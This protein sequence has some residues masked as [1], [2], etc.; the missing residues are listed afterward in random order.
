MRGAKIH[1]L[2]YKEKKKKHLLENEKSSAE[3]GGSMRS[4]NE[5]D[6]YISK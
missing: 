3:L 6:H 4:E 2:G 5:S 1:G